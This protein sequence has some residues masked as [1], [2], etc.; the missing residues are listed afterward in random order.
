[1]SSTDSK[2]DIVLPVG[3]RLCQ[4]K[5]SHGYAWVGV[6]HLPDDFVPVEGV[7]YVLVQNEDQ[8]ILVRAP[9]SEPLEHE[10]L[11]Y[12]VGDL[13]TSEIWNKTLDSNALVVR[14]L[15]EFPEDN[16]WGLYGASPFTLDDDAPSHTWCQVSNRGRLSEIDPPID[17]RGEGIGS[18]LS[19]HA[20][21]PNKNG[22]LYTLSQLQTP[23]RAH[24]YTYHQMLVRAA[25]D[26]EYRKGLRKTLAEDPDLCHLNSGIDKDFC[27]Y[28]VKLNEK[29]LMLP[30]APQSAATYQARNKV[31]TQIVR[32]ILGKTNDEPEEAPASTRQMRP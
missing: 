17:A 22:E 15:Q 25:G 13:L 7:A 3:G 28:L 1:M 4:R 26:D 10:Y 11:S 8:L 14:F 27:K 12:G 21:W 9:A 6:L 29:G 20:I 24:F 5:L 31:S 19:S 23:Y 2:S 18:L 30:D 16:V 32:E